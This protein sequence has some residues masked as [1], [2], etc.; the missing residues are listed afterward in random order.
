MK[1]CRSRAIRGLSLDGAGSEVSFN[2]PQ[3][4][5]DDEASKLFRSIQQVNLLD[6]LILIDRRLSSS[7]NAD[8]RTG[9]CSLVAL[10]HPLAQ[11]AQVHFHDTLDTFN[12]ILSS[13]DNTMAAPRAS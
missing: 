10:I 7:I 1:T 9:S 6:S 8:V 11:T 3:F 13:C 4:A 5:I 12:E 2:E